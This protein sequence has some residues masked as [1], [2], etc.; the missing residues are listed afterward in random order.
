MEKG[1]LVMMNSQEWI[2]SKNEYLIEREKGWYSFI[3]RE[4][5]KKSCKTIFSLTEKYPFFLSSFI[6]FI[7]VFFSN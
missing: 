5:F 1:F 6:F 4:I 7:G 2:G 3:K